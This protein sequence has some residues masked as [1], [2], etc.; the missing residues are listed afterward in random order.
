MSVNLLVTGA[1]GQLGQ[2]IV[3]HL[4]EIQKTDS[5]FKII[6]ATRNVEKIERFKAQGVEL[7][8]ADF[9]DA[10]SLD[11]AFKGVDRLILISTDSIGTRFTAH[12]TAIDAAVKAGVKHILYTSAN[13]PAVDRPLYDEHFLTESY[14]AAA[15]TVGFSILRNAIY[16]EI[17]LGGLPAAFAHGGTYV[18]AQGEGKRGYISRNDEA[19]A[20]AH[21]ATDKF[22]G[23][24]A[25]R[26]YEISSAELL[27]GDDVA[28]LAAEVAG[29][30]LKH[31]SVP[32]EKLVEIFSGFLPKHF[33]VAF[34]EI[35]AH[36]REGFD[37]AYTDHFEQL[38]GRRPHGLKEFL[39]ANKAALTAAPAAN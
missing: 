26:I 12:K 9:A 20:A 6:A 37:A 14:L 21:A 1:S 22:A 34:A 15:T 29:K 32:T 19:L 3:E 17:L 4:L 16:Q 24:S 13:H 39:V 28:A 5:S 2:A 33:A 38:V 10:A 25:R 8:K 35:D 7:R 23:D 31:V 27:S 18:T 36:T 30:P 11:T